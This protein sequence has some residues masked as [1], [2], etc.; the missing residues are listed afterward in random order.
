MSD[1][2]GAR[3][4]LE[5]LPKANVLLA[6]RGYDEDWFRD[7]LRK[8]GI[9]P[10]I[11]PKKNRKIKIEY[12]QTLY[13]QRHKIENMFAKLKNWHRISTRYDRCAHTFKVT[14]TIPAIV[15]WWI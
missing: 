1:Y 11:P 7:A 10:C 5:A 14:I 6:D 9:E 3:H 12:N 2:K 15:I 8:K 4:L 13:K